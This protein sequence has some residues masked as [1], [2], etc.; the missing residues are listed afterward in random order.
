[1]ETPRPIEPDGALGGIEPQAVVLG[2]VVDI[3]ATFFLG[4]AL[5]M[6]FAAERAEHYGPEIPEHFFRELAADPGY[7]FWSAVVG[8][9]CTAIGGFVAARRAGRFH[10]Q[11]G[12]VVA[13]VGIGIAV[14]FAILPSASAPPPPI[15]FQLLS[16]SVTLAGGI[17]G[18]A[19]AGL[20]RSRD[21]PEPDAD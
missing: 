1:M 16:V 18:G 8:A 3:G 9:L 20:G 12:A 6:S 7:L 21:D 13:V 4:T 5:A 11:H 15:G 10:T 19:L 14:L 17:A 2:T